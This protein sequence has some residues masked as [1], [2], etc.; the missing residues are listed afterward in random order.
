MIWLR[1][2][3]RKKIVTKLM[4]PLADG[5]WCWIFRREERA[6]LS[7]HVVTAWYLSHSLASV[8]FFSCIYSFVTDGLSFLRKRLTVTLPLLIFENYCAFTVSIVLHA[9]L[10]PLQLSRGRTANAHHLYKYLAGVKS[11]V[12]NVNIIII[13]NKRRSARW[14]THCSWDDP[15]PDEVSAVNGYTIAIGEVH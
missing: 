12:K 2:K 9:H 8:L 15:W 11:T 6:V 5:R 7:I 1:L 3:R 4:S 14:L 13:H 10:L